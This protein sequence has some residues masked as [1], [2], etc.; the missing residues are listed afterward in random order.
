MP[1]RSLL[2]RAASKLKRV[3][4]PPPPAKPMVA[5]RYDRQTAEIWSELREQYS[6]GFQTMASATVASWE[7]VAA[8]IHAATRPRLGSQAGE[9]VARFSDALV[10]TLA[11]LQAAERATTALWKDGSR[12]AAATTRIEDAVAPLVKQVQGVGA[13]IEAGWPKTTEYLA[14]ILDT[15]AVGRAGRA[16]LEAVGGH[17]RAGLDSRATEFVRTLG[18]LPRAVDFE[19]AFLDAVETWRHASAQDLE[20][21]LDQ[22]RAVL[23]EA[24]RAQ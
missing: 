22:V 18:D 7:V 2:S 8:E 16:R 6:L 23:V 12:T 10:P 4:A 9:I 1:G 13:E 14:P 21:A 3:L 20:V 17:M 24:A 5:R 19:A 11:P 15:L